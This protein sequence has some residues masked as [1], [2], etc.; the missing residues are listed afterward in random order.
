MYRFFQDE[1]GH[2]S[3]SQV[4][5]VF[6]ISKWG[7]EFLV[8]ADPDCSQAPRFSYPESGQTAGSCCSCSYSPLP[9]AQLLCSTKSKSTI[10]LSFTGVMCLSRNTFKLSRQS[11]TWH[12]DTDPGPDSVRPSV[13]RL[14]D[15]VLVS[16]IKQT[17]NGPHVPKVTPTV[18]LFPFPLT[19][20]QKQFS[21]IFNLIV[22][23]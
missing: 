16:W 18:F 11:I 23:F 22:S 12:C 21:Q 6:W 7:A 17:L 19:H 4:L 5:I 2:G 13:S 3:L 10:Y 1:S 14:L 8:T 20:S 9:A 15:T